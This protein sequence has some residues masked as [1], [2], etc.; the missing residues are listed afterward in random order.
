MALQVQA[1]DAPAT[2]GTAA[3]KS[4]KT[5]K[6]RREPAE[7]A[8]LESDED[9]KVTTHRTDGSEDYSNSKD[10]LNI[11]SW[12]LKKGSFKYDVDRV[13]SVIATADITVLQDIEFNENGETSVNVMANILEKRLNEKVCRGWF[14]NSAGKR[15]RFGFIWRDNQIAHVDKNGELRESCT[16]RPIVMRTE[17]KDYG[18]A[19]FFLKPNRRMFV[20]NA[21]DL[22]EVKN[23]D[24]E[25]PRL[26]RP[27][28]ES[29]W[30]VVYAGDT[31]TSVKNPAFK[32]VRKWNFKAAMSGGSVKGTKKT[33][34]RSLDNF[35]FKNLSLIVAEPINLYEQFPELNPSEVE[36]ALGDTVP[37]RAEFTFSDQEAEAV[38][39][40]LILKKKA[41]GPASVTPPV[42]YKGPTY[43]G[44]VS[45]KQLSSLKED[46][47]SEAQSSEPDKTTA[48]KASGKAGK[49]RRK[50]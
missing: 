49:K 16:Q 15:N 35:W 22:Q 29:E 40:Q 14:K 9:F 46:I 10:R 5:K 34:K 44:A 42:V 20:L 23:P 48:K 8:L 31:K 7:E 39:T 27:H 24:R 45:E 37:L 28:S 12:K 2:G 26:F 25:M 3:S 6:E 43:P 1:A 32:D 33:V 19:T 21:L 38:Q 13:A 11:V 18:V 17:T 4:K 47:E 30:P 36:A 50:K 41:K